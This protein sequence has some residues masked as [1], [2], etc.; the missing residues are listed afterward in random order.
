M[1]LRTALAWGEEGTSATGVDSLSVARLGAIDLRAQ[2][3]I[4]SVLRTDT[5][6]QVV[7]RNGSR[8]AYV[9]DSSSGQFPRQQQG[10]RTQA[11]TGNT[12]N[13]RATRLCLRHA[14]GPSVRSSGHLRNS[15]VKATS[16]VSR[17]RVAPRQ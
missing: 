2:T 13:P 7:E 11:R 12:D 14:G 1:L 5:P 4:P 10:D 6:T 3:Q 8:C 9:L 17:A 15:V 16:A